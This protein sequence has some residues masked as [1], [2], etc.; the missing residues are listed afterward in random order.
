MGHATAVAAP[1]DLLRTPTF[2]WLTTGWVLSNFADSALTLILAIWVADLTGS[3]TAGGLTFA[4]IGL[5]SLGAPFLGAL[6]DRVSRRK[7]LAT[8]YLVGAACLVPLLWVHHGGQVWLIYAATVLYAATGYVTGAGQSG[9]LRDLLPDAALGHAN[10]RL[11]TIDQGFRIAMPFVGAGVYAAFGPHLLVA[12][13][14]IAFTAAAIVFLALRI[15]ES[16]I[17][18]T[19]RLTMA[20][21]SS[22]FRQLFTLNPLRPLTVT[23]L[24]AFA[25]TGLIDGAV[26]AILDA[27]GIPRAW[28]PPLLV[29]QGVGGFAAGMLAPRLMARWG[30]PRLAA[31]GLLLAGLGLAPVPLALIPLVAVSQVAVGLGTTAAIIAY[32]TERH[33]VTPAALQGRAAAASQVLLSFPHVLFTAAGAALL[34]V[35]DWRVIVLINVAALLVCGIAGLLIRSGPARS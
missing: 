25:F 16:V 12:A 17:P 11:S 14:I 10:S 33:M 23:L 15:D 31:A 18:A 29:L 9:L 27:V 28:L 19:Q 35:L 6:A 8:S 7:L 3:I 26:F 13:S 22:G 32:T 24:V 34:V 30:R 20:E 21:L 4:M 2:R 1:G 5:P